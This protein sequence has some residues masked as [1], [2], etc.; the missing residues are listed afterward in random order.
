MAKEVEIIRKLC[1]KGLQEQQRK[2]RGSREMPG[3]AESQGTAGESQ[4]T[5]EESNGVAQESQKI[6]EESKRKAEES[7]RVAQERAKHLTQSRVR[8]R[9]VHLLRKA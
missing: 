6:A 2:V 7:N 4:G 5:A 9:P 1:A 3:A 8:F